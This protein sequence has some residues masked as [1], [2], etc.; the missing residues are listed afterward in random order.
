MA[1]TQSHESLD[2]EEEVKGPSN[3]AFGVTFAAVFA[4]IGLL[5]LVGGREPRFWA[6]AVA[7]LFLLAAFLAPAAM[8]PLNRLWL[9]LGLVLHRVVGPL[10]L[11]FVF[12]A[13][14]TPTAWLMRALGKDPLGLGFDRSASSYWIPR[15]P[16]GPDSE[17]M[18]HQF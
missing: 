13:V 2:R 10:V 3:R 14:L 1:E 16:R 9:K 4:V 17:T 18:R 5:P 11:G 12:F 8:A 15:T 7:A 6:L